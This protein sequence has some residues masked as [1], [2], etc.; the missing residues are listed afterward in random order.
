MKVAGFPIGQAK[1][2]NL[3]YGQLCQA[4]KE[5]RNFKVRIH[6][7]QALMAPSHANQYH[8]VSEDQVVATTVAGFGISEGETSWLE[9][10]Q[11]ILSSELK[12]LTLSTPSLEE[13]VMVKGEEEE[14]GKNDY[15]RQY[16]LLINSCLM[17]LKVL[18]GL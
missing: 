8:S 1:W 12:R 11:R 18:S 5:P 15:Q 2:T 17:H 16:A 4:L 9:H 6:A 13:V 14:A 7:V 3:V 10:I